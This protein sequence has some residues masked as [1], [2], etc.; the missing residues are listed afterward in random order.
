[1]LGVKA[2]K[3]RHLGYD[4]RKSPQRPKGRN[5]DITITGRRMQVGE[6]LK[7]FVEERLDN[8]T[9]VF[10]I[11]PMTVEVILRRESKPSRKNPNACEITLRTKGHIIRTEAADEDVRAAI[12]IATA[13]LERQL[14]KFK[15][16]VLDR[17]QSAVKLADVLESE[18]EA[19][20]SSD[21]E[22]LETE[23]GL[24]RIKVIELAVLNTEDAMLQM[25]LLG[26]DF[27]VYVAA[28]DGTTCV[29][30]RRHEGG[31]GLLK[32]Q[33]ESVG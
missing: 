1:M 24:V 16:K 11:D 12:D 26:H 29:M 17:R 23:Q 4:S 20:E 25:D 18:I 21:I 3:Q 30:Y 28:E 15:T 31:Y 8:A 33:L 27:Y 7:E 5:M 32:P 2:A 10:K 22:E 13:K 14:R 19:P 9:K 6:D